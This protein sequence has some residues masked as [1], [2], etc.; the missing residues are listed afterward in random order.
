MSLSQSFMWYTDIANIPQTSFFFSGQG[1]TLHIKKLVSI[2]PWVK[3][4][5]IDKRGYLLLNTNGRIIVSMT[6]QCEGGAWKDRMDLGVHWHM[7]DLCPYAHPSLSRRE[8]HKK[9]LGGIVKTDILLETRKS[10]YHVSESARMKWTTPDEDERRSGG[11]IGRARSEFGVREKE[12]HCLPPSG[13]NRKL[14]N[15]LHK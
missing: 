4:W 7:F 12:H 10:K 6:G 1:G 11:R 3:Y 9:W 2:R 14:K 13:L 15:V 8:N 5:E